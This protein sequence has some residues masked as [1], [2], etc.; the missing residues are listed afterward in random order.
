MDS[1]YMVIKLNVPRIG[2]GGSHLHFEEKSFV[3]CFSRLSVRAI[4]CQL[5]V[6]LKMKM[7]CFCVGCEIGIGGGNGATLLEGEFLLRLRCRVMTVLSCGQ[8]VYIDGW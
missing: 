3:D 8:I 2:G 4:F 6:Q 7:F 1:I 5:S